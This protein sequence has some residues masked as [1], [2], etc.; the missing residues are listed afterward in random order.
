MESFGDFCFQYSYIETAIFPSSCKYFG[1]QIFTSCYYLKTIE[2]KS[3]TLNISYPM[4]TVSDII[5]LTSVIFHTPENSS[6]IRSFQYLRDSTI[7]NYIFD[8]EILVICPYAFMISSVINVT[9]NKHITEIPCGCFY[10]CTNLSNIN[11]NNIKSIQNFA[12]YG[13]VIQFDIPNVNN[14]GTYAFYG[15]RF[16]GTNLY[17]TNITIIPAYSFY[18]TEMNSFTISSTVTRI[19]EGAFEVSNIYC[20]LII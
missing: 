6:E 4:F 17:L 12:F 2:F 1:K 18:G 9:L 8:E 11:L 14:I 5:A 3:L 15:N 7:K 13:V 20:D 19:E 16:Y 10:G